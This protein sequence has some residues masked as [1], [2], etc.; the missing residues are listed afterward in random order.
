[1]DPSGTAQYLLKDGHDSTRQ[2][3]SALGLVTDYYGYDAYGIMLG[4][5]PTSSNPS[6]T[7]LLYSGEQFD[8]GLG[9]YNLRSRFYDPSSGRFTTMDTY[10][11]SLQDPQSLHKYAYCHADPI[12]YHDP[13]GHD[14]DLAEILT[15]L[16]ITSILVATS[17]SVLKSAV[18]G[19]GW[20]PDA[21]LVGA[22]LSISGFA[23]IIGVLNLASQAIYG[24]GNS[25]GTFAAGQLL[26][27]ANLSALSTTT[28]NLGKFAGASANLG[29]EVLYTTGDN[30]ISN[31]TYYGPGFYISPG[32]G[33]TLG[34]SITVYAGVCW[35]VPTWDSYSGGFYSF[36]LGAGSGAFGWAVSYFWSDST[37]AQNGFNVGLTASF[38]P[39]DGLSFGG[40]SF[41]YIYYTGNAWAAWDSPGE[42]LGLLV[43]VP[44]VGIPWS[45]VLGYKWGMKSS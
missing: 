4:G 45:Y 12:N 15:V 17:F 42:I 38:P 11:G 39:G 29:S 37:P 14:G 10:E 13:S 7:R 20:F 43:L 44:G 31:W 21:A 8:S 19:G 1:M 34:G 22:S 23:P 36:S 35:A 18:Y 40:A 9:Q 24:G 26:N 6:A 33:N 16:F 25:V 2:L 3:A 32:G 5:N 27:F 41:S 28:Q 30:M